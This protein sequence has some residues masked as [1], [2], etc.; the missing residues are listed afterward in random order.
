M[1]AKK[2][3]SICIVTFNDRDNLIKTLSSIEFSTELEIIIQDG[4]SNYNVREILKQFINIK[5]LIKLARE[6]DEGIYDAMNKAVKRSTGEFVMFLNC[7]DRLANSI[8]PILLEL[9]PKVDKSLECVKFLADVEGEGIRLER[10]SKFFF[11]RKMLNHQSIV[12]RRTCFFSTRYDPK[13][14]IAGDLKHFL[15]ANLLEKIGYVDLVLINYL[16]GGA[17]AKKK[18]IRQNWSDRASAW[19]W[20][21]KLSLKCILML[22]VIIRYFLYIFRIKT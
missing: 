9:L 21:I 7:G 17:A 11:F 16:N 3:L 20:D 2:R 18:G 19:K 1:I 5:P 12:Y 14:Q 22:A 8:Q 4:K 13:M 6:S 15:E 10:A